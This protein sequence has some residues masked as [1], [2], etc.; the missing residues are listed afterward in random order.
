MQKRTI[1]TEGKDLFFLD[2]RDFVQEINT[3]NIPA[4]GSLHS[5]FAFYSCIQIH[6]LC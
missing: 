3:L 2:T 5:A 1:S 6:Q 4:V